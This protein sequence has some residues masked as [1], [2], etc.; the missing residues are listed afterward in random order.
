MARN[1]VEPTTELGRQ[2]EKER[3]NQ[4]LT[5]EAWID[6]IYVSKP[7]YLGWLRGAQPEL[8]NIFQIAEALAIEPDE[9]FSWVASD[10]AKGVYVSSISQLALDLSLVA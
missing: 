2:L 5:K 9:V 8:T 4:G 10:Y 1:E 6:L 3:K 7:T